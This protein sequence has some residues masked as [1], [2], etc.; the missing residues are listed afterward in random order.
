VT[1]TRR[2]LFNKTGKA[3]ASIALTPLLPSALVTRAMADETAPLTGIA[4]IDRVTI[5][6]GKTYLRGW[7]GYGA[8]PAPTRGRGPQPPSTPTGPA[9]T[10]IWT[11]QS[12]P[13]TVTFADPRSL[14]TTA[15]FST[16][17]AFVLQL[18][19]AN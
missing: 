10:V 4:G 18:T 3:A 11:K 19:P 8:P 2:A 1:I 14:I 9:P 13:G 7:A 17:G 15:S 5:L 16:P 12:G 6:P